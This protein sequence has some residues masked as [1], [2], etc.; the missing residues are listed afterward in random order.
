MRAE[1]GRPARPFYVSTSPFN[2]LTLAHSGPR[3]RLIASLKNQNDEIWTLPLS[4]KGFR[5]AGEPKRIVSSTRDEAHP[6]L[7]RR[8]LARLP[9]RTE[10]G[11]GNMAS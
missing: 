8:S 5:A 7:T 9:K 2:E 11:V 1:I 6:R 4:A 3:P 10:R